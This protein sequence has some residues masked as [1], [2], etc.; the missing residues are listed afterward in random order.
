LVAHQCLGSI[1][2]R[3]HDNRLQ[4]DKV[5]SVY[6]TIKQFN[7]VSHYVVATILQPKLSLAERA[8]VIER[9]INIAQV[10]VWSFWFSIT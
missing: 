2:S 10:C 6:A 1:W 5:A 7:A 9:W 8:C 3:R 4:A